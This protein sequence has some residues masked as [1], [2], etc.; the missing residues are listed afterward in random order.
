ML[1]SRVLSLRPDHL[2]ARLL[3][4]VLLTNE[5]TVLFVCVGNAARSLMAEAFFN[6][7]PPTG[8]RAVSA[9][10]QPARLPNPRTAPML[11]EVGVAPPPHR[12][13]ALTE[14][15]TDSA[16][17]RIT[18]GCLDEASCPA[19]LKSGPVEDWGL[20]DP[21]ALADPEFRSVRDE[22]RRR[23]AELRTRL[24]SLPK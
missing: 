5:R 8:W 22:I 14:S 24:S 7:D 18:M 6:A 19:R 16:Q 10:T 4:R 1:R 17:V 20:P 21:A 3:R 12:P 13:Q 9:G 23:V 2:P 15:M 11:A